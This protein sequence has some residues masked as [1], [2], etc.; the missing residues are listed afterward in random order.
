[1]KVRIAGFGPVMVTMPRLRIGRMGRQ[2]AQQRG[3]EK[4]SHGHR[5][6]L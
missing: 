6:T 1:L 3:R 4:D 2:D 5:I